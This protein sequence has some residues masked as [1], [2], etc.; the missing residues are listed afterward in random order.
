[1]KSAFISYSWDDDQHCEWVRKL[2]ERLRA[3]GVD[4]SID[5]WMVRYPRRS[6][7]CIHGALHSRE[8]LCCD[9]LYSPLQKPVGLSCGWCR[10][11][12]RHYDS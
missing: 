12:R 7:T 4:V 5:R 9:H 8:S 11:R 1:M 10:L 3:D 6:T 2:A